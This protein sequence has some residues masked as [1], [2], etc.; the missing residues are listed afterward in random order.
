MIPYLCFLL[1]VCWKKQN[2]KQYIR[3]PVCCRQESC[4]LTSSTGAFEIHIS[5]I[6][7]G[8]WKKDTPKSHGRL[9]STGKLPG[10]GAGALHVGWKS[11][12]WK[13]STCMQCTFHQSDTTREADGHKYAKI[14]FAC[15]SV[16]HLGDVAFLSSFF[17][18]AGVVDHP[19]YLPYPCAWDRCRVI[20]GRWARRFQL[21]HR[22][23]RLRERL[24]WPSLPNST[25][26]ILGK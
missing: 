10:G 1:L 13:N 12:A 20:M 19:V 9:E 15:N 2:F 16:H 17:C 5:S 7:G 25:H 14:S 23:A 6:R 11:R 3:N 4:A 8:E 18:S 26:T 24:L 22:A 21:W